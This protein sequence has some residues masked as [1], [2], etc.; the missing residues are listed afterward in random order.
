MIPVVSTTLGTITGGDLATGLIVLFV[1]SY[2]I[3]SNSYGGSGS[4]SSSSGESKSEKSSTKEKSTESGEAKE[5]TKEEETAT[6]EEE[7]EVSPDSFSSNRF[8]M[9]DDEGP[10]VEDGKIKLY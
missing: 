1:I 9:D 10:K 7:P 5:E 2:I 8:S 6:K 3:A 4:A